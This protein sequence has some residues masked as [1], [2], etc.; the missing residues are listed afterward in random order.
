MPLKTVCKDKTA[1][2]KTKKYNVNYDY[3]NVNYDYYIS[4]TKRWCKLKI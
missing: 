2:I 1:H 4:M 3:Y